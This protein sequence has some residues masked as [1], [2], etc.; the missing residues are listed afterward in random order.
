MRSSLVFPEYTKM[1]RV[2]QS[3]LLGEKLMQVTE[4]GPVAN[5][6]QSLALDDEAS[7]W[8]GVFTIT[9]DREELFPEG[10]PLAAIS[11]PL[12]QPEINLDLSRYSDDED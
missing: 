11:F 1:Q 12:W 8:R 6:N 3:P 9:L 7:P 4:D 2:K 10:L 5:I